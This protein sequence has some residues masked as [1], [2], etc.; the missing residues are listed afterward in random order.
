MNNPIL[1][2][3]YA[4]LV[5]EK[6]FETMFLDKKSSKLPLVAQNIS[7]TFILNFRGKIGIANYII[8]SVSSLWRLPSSSRYSVNFTDR[9]EVFPQ[10]TG[11]AHF[12]STLFIEFKCYLN[13]VFA[14][15]IL[16]A[17]VSSALL[18]FTISL[19]CSMHLL[20]LLF[21]Q[22]CRIY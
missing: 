18:V 20:Y 15:L 4:V 14:V 17:P 16:I 6:T 12:K 22:T 11:G 13:I 9:S 3:K 7:S 1:Y 8:P 19:H 5:G 2:V 10:C 21:R